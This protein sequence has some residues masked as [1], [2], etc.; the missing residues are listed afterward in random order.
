MKRWLSIS[1][2]F[3]SLLGVTA[4]S[5]LVFL[6]LRTSATPASVV[7]INQ[8]SSSVAKAK[9]GSFTTAQK[10]FDERGIALS[11]QP[12]A[13]LTNAHWHTYVLGDDAQVNQAAAELQSEWLKYS[14]NT[15]KASGLKTI[16]LV[17]DLHVDGQ[18]RSGFPEPRIE[19]ALYFDI[20]ANYLNSENGQYLRRTFH[21]EFAHLI[22][23]DLFGSFAPADAA[24]NRCNAKDTKYGNGGPSMYADVD[25]AHTMHP[26][27]GFVDGYAT[28]GL[29]EDK[30][31]M[32]AY[33]MT[34]P[35]SVQNLADGDAGINCK[36]QL[37]ERLLQEL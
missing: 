19:H 8:K 32:F 29:D 5:L 3:G 11:I 26:K 9:A 14:A 28:S 12:K 4:V 37:T 30:A 23:Y 17:H 36:L 31:E 34:D 7:P 22:E 1:F 21:H 6:N 33:Y 24:W 16:Y 20:S 27:Y 25:Y 2:S 35:A 10:F 15:L 13:T 18:A